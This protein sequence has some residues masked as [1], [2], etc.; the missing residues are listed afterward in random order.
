L[1]PAVITFRPDNFLTI[2]LIGGVVYVSAV[3]LVQ[4]AMRAGLIKATAP[5]SGTA[6]AVV[7]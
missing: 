3:I 6:P 1:E 7:V 4:L 5:A 2:G